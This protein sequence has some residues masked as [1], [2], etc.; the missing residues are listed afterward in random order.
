MQAGVWEY[1]GW[2][3]KKN[4]TRGLSNL[5]CVTTPCLLHVLFRNPE[6]EPGVNFRQ[7]K[8]L[9]FGAVVPCHAAWPWISRQR[10]F[11]TMCNQAKR[12]VYSP[13]FCIGN[14]WFDN[15]DEFRRT[16]A[17]PVQRASGPDIGACLSQANLFHSS[18]NC[19]SFAVVCN[20]FVCVLSWHGL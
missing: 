6:I 15:A 19:F 9:T 2:G 7:R 3:R 14:P 5:S 13:S 11:P 18:P 12:P 17:K 4:I 20:L 8:P 1:H 16:V 10:P